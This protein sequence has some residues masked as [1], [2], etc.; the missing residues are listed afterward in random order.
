[1]GYGGRGGGGGRG[2]ASAF[3]QRRVEIQATERQANRQAVGETESNYNYVD[4]GSGGLCFHPLHDD[5]EVMLNV[6][7]CQLTYEG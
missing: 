4:E 2:T 5:D 6:L 7:R 3:I 1:M